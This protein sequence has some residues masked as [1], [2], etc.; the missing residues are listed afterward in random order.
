[1]RTKS[2]QEKY[3]EPLHHVPDHEQLSRTPKWPRRTIKGTQAE[4][5]EYNTICALL[6]RFL[7]SVRVKRGPNFLNDGF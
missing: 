2:G 7:W 3:Q 1:M 4:M 6:H 5:L